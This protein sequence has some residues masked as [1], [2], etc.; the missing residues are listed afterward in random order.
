TGHAE[1]APARPRLRLKFLITTGIAAVI[2]LA[3]YWTEQ[4]GLISFREMARPG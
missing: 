2:W 1:S 3:I 4:S